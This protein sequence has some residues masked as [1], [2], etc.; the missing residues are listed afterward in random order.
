MCHFSGPLEQVPTQPR[1]HAQAA[2]SRLSP[3]HSLSPRGAQ[4]R[5]LSRCCQPAGRPATELLMPLARMGLLSQAGFLCRSGWRPLSHRGH[6]RVKGPICHRIPL[7]DRPHAFPTHFPFLSLL[8]S[9][10]NCSQRCISTL[11]AMSCRSR[12]REHAHR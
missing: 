8:L 5:G 4:T 1:G 11:T 3:A 2:P 9:P 10:L 7:A 12:C 6:C